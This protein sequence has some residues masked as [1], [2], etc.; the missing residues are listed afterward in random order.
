MT[1]DIPP[2]GD[3]RVE[4]RGSAWTAVNV[5]DVEIS[6]GERAK[7]VD[8]DG[9]TLQEVLDSVWQQPCCDL[10]L[11]R[12]QILSMHELLDQLHKCRQELAELQRLDWDHWEEFRDHILMLDLQSQPDPIVRDYAQ[13]MKRLSATLSKLWQD[14]N[15]AA[16]T[17]L[18]N[19]LN[20]LAARLKSEAR[21]IE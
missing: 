5:G 18:A 13:K 1:S 15:A 20:E 17:T 14:D 19:G 2:G 12:D 16:R 3:A 10:S 6:S 21:E 4:H 8:I 9:L 7:I 11:Y